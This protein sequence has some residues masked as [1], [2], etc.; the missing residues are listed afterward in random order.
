MGK[1]ILFAVICCK[2]RIDKI[3]HIQKNMQ[4]AGINEYVIVLG[5]DSIPISYFDDNAKILYLKC[6]DAYENLPEK[7]ICLFDYVYN[8]SRFKTFSYLYKL[9][10]DCTFVKKVNL[11][12]LYNRLSK[13]DYGGIRIHGLH[14]KGCKR[15]NHFGKV[16]PGSY[17]DNRLAKPNSGIGFGHVHGG[18]G[19][20]ISYPM[21]YKVLQKYN[22]SNID[23]LNENEI[24]DD[25]LIAEIC[26][27]NKVHATFIEFDELRGDHVTNYKKK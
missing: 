19:L 21:I 20:Y 7:C 18:C 23:K 16:T 27:E 22:K 6:H 12:D 3:T 14:K 2:K 5:D 26:F 17:W 4:S 25:V 24:Y 11:N 8:D 9:D 10:D 1:R 15:D 13:S